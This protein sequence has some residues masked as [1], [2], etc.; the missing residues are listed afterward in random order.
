[1]IGE[2]KLEK[3]KI[4][5][6]NF[7]LN[8]S[9]DQITLRGLRENGVVVKEI[10]DKTPGLKKYINIAREFVACEKE[11]DLYMIGY[12]GS[13]LVIFIRLLSFRTRKRIVYNAL[14][15]FYDSMIVSRGGGSLLSFSAPW[16]YLIDFLAFRFA[17]QSF[18]ECQTQKDL[19]VGVFKINPDKISVCFVG[20]DDEK[21]YFDPE[22]PKLNNFTVVFRGAFLPEAG[23]DI[24]VQAAKELESE[25]ISVRILGRGLLLK[26][27]QDL[28]Q[29][30]KPSNV[31]LIT[32]LL[33]I[34]ILRNKM[35][36]CHLS[37][38]QLADHPRVQ[39][40]V[41]H[42]V[43]ESMAMKLP[44]LTGENKGVLEVVRD[45]QTCFAVPPGDY[46]SLAH[47]IVELRN[48][49]EELNRVAENAYHLYQQEFTPKILAQKILEKLHLKN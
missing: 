14:A 27:I 4:C 49:P 30:L 13:V 41:P 10:A 38:G 15:T 44:Y 46:R 12:A 19:V 45:G 16:Y 47:K 23:A 11:Y 33:P 28:I 25:N 8:N 29:E 17:S 36:E 21:F 40:T 6:I 43:F 2:F 9:R 3:M 18:L 39:T 20:T 35:L 42:K 24:V 1:M 31:E 5:Y 7:N 32:E 22:I 26:Q 34:D 37:L 48:R